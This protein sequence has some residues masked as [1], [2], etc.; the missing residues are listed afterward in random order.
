MAIFPNSKGFKFSANSN[1]LLICIY[2]IWLS[3]PIEVKG[4]NQTNNVLLCVISDNG[5][6]IQTIFQQSILFGPPTRATDN[7]QSGEHDRARKIIQSN[8]TISFEVFILSKGQKSIPICQQ[9]IHLIIVNHFDWGNMFTKSISMT[10]NQIDSEIEMKREK[11]RDRK[12]PNKIEFFFCEW[13]I[14]FDCRI[15]D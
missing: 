2:W 9:R 11:E 10:A 1:D 5:R 8:C 3:V 12:L 6:N 14:R 4:L 15:S 7:R 13:I